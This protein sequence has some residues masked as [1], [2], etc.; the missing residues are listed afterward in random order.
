[1]ITN[2]QIDALERLAAVDDELRELNAELERE[3]EA[4]TA[5]KEQL[6]EL[7]GKLERDQQSLAEMERMRGD[8][9]QEVRQMSVQ[10]EKSREKLGRCRTEREANAAQRELEELRKLFR[11]R[12]H[13]IGKLNEL[14]EQARG[15]IDSVTGQRDSLTGELGANE[16][17]VTTRLAEVERQ[18]EARSEVRKQAAAT[19]TKLDAR[20]YR[21]Y[22]LVRKRLGTAVAVTTDG[23][24]AACHVRMPPM[25]FQRL[26]RREDFGQ[27]PSCNR[28][29]YFREPE[30][31]AA[32]DGQ[33]AD[34]SATGP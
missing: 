6:Q 3:R 7:D 9:V 34:N 23:S 17:Q 10:I 30:E 28:I 8:L 12:E 18:V 14:A 4:L 1:V 24:C 26:L 21:R 29:I 15:E 2:E 25:Q 33:S 32:S 22:E 11:D 20:V 13:E 16:G 27:C 31:A 5:K 19:L